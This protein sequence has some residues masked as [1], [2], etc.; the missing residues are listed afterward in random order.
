MPL[1]KFALSFIVGIGISIQALGDPLFLDK[2]LSAEKI[3]DLANTLQD[4]D[5]T[6]VDGIPVVNAPCQFHKEASTPFPDDYKFKNPVFHEK[7]INHPDDDTEYAFTLTPNGM[8]GKYPS[9]YNNCRLVEDKGDNVT[10]KC[11]ENYYRF[12]YI[13]RKETTHHFEKTCWVYVVPSSDGTFDGIPYHID[14]YGKWLSFSNT[15]PPSSLKHDTQ[16]Q[17]CLTLD[18]VRPTLPDPIPECPV[19]PFTTTPLPKNTQFKNPLFAMEMETHD[20][21]E[22][23]FIFNLTPTSITFHRSDM[24]EKG[25]FDCDLIENNMTNITYYCKIFP[26]H[27]KPYKNYDGFIRFRSVGHEKDFLGDFKYSLC[28]ILVHTKTTTENDLKKTF[29]QLNSSLLNSY[30]IKTTKCGPTERFPVLKFS[31]PSVF[32]GDM[33]VPPK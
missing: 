9:E 3:T 7:F 16:A 1:L 14:D 31:Q 12:H 25:H 24:E 5:T 15:C 6:L 18:D 30:R 28:Q 13:G 10:Y 8:Q 21:Y 2:S 32:P 4:V 33:C 26:Q 17:Q 19:H 11:N 23:T 20:Y 29:D 22:G 27:L